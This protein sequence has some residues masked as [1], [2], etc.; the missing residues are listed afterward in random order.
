M[1]S[2]VD[3]TPDLQD[4][5]HLAGLDMIQGSQTHDGRTIIWNKGGETR[6]YVDFMDGWNVVT[7]S[8]RMGPESFSFAGK[9]MPITEKYLYGAFGGSVRNRDL[10]LIR[11]PFERHQLRPG[12]AIEKQFFAGRERSTLVDRAG[13]AVAIAATDRLVAL[14]HYLDAS[15]DAIKASFEAPDGKPLFTVW[16]NTK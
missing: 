11:A 12:Y 8:D 3:L 13:H 2:S 9:S 4:W 10:P 6:N 7:S 5:I 16:D 1:R 15:V 14:S